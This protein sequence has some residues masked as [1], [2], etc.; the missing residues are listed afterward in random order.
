MRSIKQC[1]VVVP[2][3]VVALS[4]TQNAFSS[5]WIICDN[6][7]PLTSFWEQPFVGVRFSL[8]KRVSSAHLLTV[9]FFTMTEC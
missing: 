5:Q 8:H 2:A 1:A 3:I 6:N 9:S 4:S 7:T